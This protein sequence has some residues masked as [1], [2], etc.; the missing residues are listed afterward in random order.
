MICSSMNVPTFIGHPRFPERT[1]EDPCAPPGEI[2]MTLISFV[3]F[4]GGIPALSR[5]VAF[6]KAEM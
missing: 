6:F 2:R 1:R 4:Q 5:S 3:H